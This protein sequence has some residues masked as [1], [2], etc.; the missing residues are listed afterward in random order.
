M[1]VFTWVIYGEKVTNVIVAEITVYIVNV[2]R[3]TYHD[4]GGWRR[5]ARVKSILRKPHKHGAG[6]V[7]VY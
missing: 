1:H 7:A 5:R 3:G 2:P 6:A 4:R